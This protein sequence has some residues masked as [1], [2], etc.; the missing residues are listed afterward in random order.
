MSR[1]RYIVVQQAS[2]EALLNLAE[3]L[4]AAF[5]EESSDAER[6]TGAIEEMRN[7]LLDYESPFLRHREEILGCYSTAQRLSALSLHLWNDN[8][9]VRLA[10]LFGNADTRH[11]LIALELI[12]SYAVQG[13]N[14]PHFMNLADEIRDLK[15]VAAQAA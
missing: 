4:A 15:S 10:S 3:A 1:P 9:P 7:A 5:P 2:V 14:D 11:T 12:A 13:E 6:T 8:N